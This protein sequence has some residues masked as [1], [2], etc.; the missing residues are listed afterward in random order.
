MRHVLPLLALMACS[1]S[2]DIQAP[3]DQASSPNGGG[4]EPTG[5]V[6]PG[7]SPGQATD[8]LAVSQRPRLQWKRYAALEA[9]LASALELPADQLC[10]EFGSASCIRDVHLVPL[11]GHEP[12]ETGMLEPAA[13]PLATTPT[14][15]ERV[16]LSA[17]SAR[18]ERD[19]SEH[20]LFTFDLAGKA[21]ADDALGTT[22]YRRF[23]ARD[24]EPVE[25]AALRELAVDD[26][27]PI[28][29]D[30]YAKL[31]CFLVGTQSEFLFF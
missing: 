16:V 11:G 9:D 14:V 15:I 6:D 12:Y 23:L 26:S 25:L 18:V 19:R 27:G 3:K 4:K 5:S 7:K 1:S 20:K 22:L 2:S 8:K 13:E 31:A 24:P 10:T 21:V 17:C 28:A 30:E 29:A